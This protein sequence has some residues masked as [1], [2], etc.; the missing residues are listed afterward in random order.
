[1]TENIF[2]KLISELSEEMD[3][4]L[5]KLSYNDWVLQL[6][7]GNKVRHIIG[8]RFDLN[9]EA[10]GNIAC[11]K[12]AT[13]QVL[14]SRK[15]PAVEHELLFN[16]ITRTKYI[17]DDGC[18]GIIEKYFS[19]YKTLVVKPNDGSEG[20]G[21][22]LCHNI[23][24]VEVAINRL[25]K[26]KDAVC[27]CPYYDIE[28]E[29]RT[30]YLNGEILLIYGKEKPYIIGDGQKNIGELIADLNLPDNN[31]V[32]DNL[33][34]L[35]HNQILQKGE[36]INLSWKHNLSG[37]ANPHILEKSELYNEIENLAIS[38]GNI[39]NMKFATIDVVKT[40]DGKL[41]VLE[42][43]SGIGISNFISKV[44]VGYEIAKGIFRKA[45]AS[46]FEE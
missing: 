36:K 21:V 2:H 38:A 7:K 8:Y 26:T 22:F 13:Y 1:M 24:D 33:K 23:K 5:E 16:P 44:D 10:S 29:Y 14:N 45:L 32:N 41:R 18:Y 37:G 43:N 30:F 39:M 35:N 28:I 6:T 9:T 27:I 31:V 34:E 42:V 15:I 4:G 17:S 40:T 46:M 20:N 3:I 11:D 25:F 19:M 12:A